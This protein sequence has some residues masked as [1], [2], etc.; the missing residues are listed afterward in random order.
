M[1]PTC[2]RSDP[3]SKRWLGSRVKNTQPMEITS[4][5]VLRVHR[6]KVIAASSSG[7]PSQQRML[8]TE[9]GVAQLV[10]TGTVFEVTNLCWDKGNYIVTSKSMSVS[11]KDSVDISVLW[12][13]GGSLKTS[14]AEDVP[15]D[16]KYAVDLD[17][18]S[19]LACNNFLS[20]FVL[21]LGAG[22]VFYFCRSFW[23]TVI[24][25]VVYIVVIWS[26]LRSPWNNLR[27][28]TTQMPSRMDII[29]PVSNSHVPLPPPPLPFPSSVVSQPFLQPVPFSSSSS[30]SSVPSAP[31]TSPYSTPSTTYPPFYPYPYSYQQ[32]QQPSPQPQMPQ[33]VN[34]SVG[35]ASTT[36]PTAAPYPLLSEA[37]GDMID[38]RV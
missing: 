34:T 33:Y 37:S 35:T 8:T 2:I 3:I 14:V 21:G 38:Y 10:P 7:A 11:G 27:T 29:A 17:P 1:W 9:Q 26:V 32:S 13:P 12:K 28:P 22:V 19:C 25:L 20:I 16:E 15:F 24:I 36:F 5:G 4:E 6:P 23:L 18:C 31:S 30:S